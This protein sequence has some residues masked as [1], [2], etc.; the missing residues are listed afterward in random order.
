MS[1]VDISTVYKIRNLYKR[2]D[3]VTWTIRDA[4]Q[5]FPL[6]N[7]KNI[8]GLY[9]IYVEMREEVRNILLDLEEINNV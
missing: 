3:Q 8:L 5:R 1:K 4:Q 9:N 7:E 6:T 2:L